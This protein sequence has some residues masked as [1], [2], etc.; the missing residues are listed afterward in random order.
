[1][2]I[3]GYMNGYNEKE[4]GILVAHD[5]ALSMLQF[6]F[7]KPKSG[8][9]E[10]TGHFLHRNIMDKEADFI[11]A[12]LYNDSF[13]YGVVGVNTQ[14]LAFLTSPL[15]KEMT[16]YS[17]WFRSLRIPLVISEDVYNIEETGETRHI[18][19]IIIGEEKKRLELYEA[20]DACTAKERQNKLINRD[21]FYEA[22]RIF[23]ESDYYR[24]RNKFSEIFKEC[25]DD[26]VVKWYLFESERCLNGFVDQVMPGRLRVDD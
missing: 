25:P 19:F 14:S 10:K 9:I 8:V 1:M 12:F 3:I 20:L 21:K 6:L 17:E 4:D 2:N 15:N 26:M 22:L 24:A 11:S 5:G 13:Y 18:G 7:L 16:V 23:Y